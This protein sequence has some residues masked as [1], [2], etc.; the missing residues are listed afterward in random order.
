MQAQAFID[1]PYLPLGT[2]YSPSVYRRDVIDI[3]H[4][5]PIF[6]NMKRA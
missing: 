1:V 6:W 2:L 5:F 3:V 4:G